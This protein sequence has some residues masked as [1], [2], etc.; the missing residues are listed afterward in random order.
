MPRLPGT[1][2]C[3]DDATRLPTLNV[4]GD[5]PAATGVLHARDWLEEVTPYLGDRQDL[6]DVRFRGLGHAFRVDQGR[7]LV[8]ELHLDGGET[9]WPGRLGGL[10]GNLDLAST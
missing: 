4:A 1:A 8:E 5:W 7:Y 3:R 9:D 10:D 6:K 2:T